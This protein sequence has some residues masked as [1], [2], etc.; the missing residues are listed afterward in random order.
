[1]LY[2]YPTKLVKDFD[3]ILNCPVRSSCVIASECFINGTLEN[4]RTRKRVQSKRQELIW[5]FNEFGNHVYIIRSGITAISMLGKDGSETV[6]E[7][8]SPGWAFGLTNLFEQEKRPL[9]ARACTCLELCRVSAHEIEKIIPKSPSL[10]KKVIRKLSE[11][12]WMLA[13]QQEINAYPLAHD[14][15]KKLLQR[16]TEQLKD[17]N[18]EVQIPLTHNDI[19]GMTGVSRVTATRVLSILEKEGFVSLGNR[20]IRLNPEAIIRN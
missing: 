2:K 13:C 4:L 18:E 10:A 11:I 1:M 16:L 17:G 14:R 8:L 9:I 15:I 12:P 5:C 7:I 6:L 19:A 20:C 3:A